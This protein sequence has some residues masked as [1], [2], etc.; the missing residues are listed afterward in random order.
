MTNTI[1]KKRKVFIFVILFLLFNGILFSLFQPSV[2]ITLRGQEDTL[3]HFFYDNLSEDYPFDD[4]HMATFDYNSKNGIEAIVV[5]V[6]L[7]N[8]N[9]LRI[10]F[11]T[12]PTS[13]EIYSFSILKSPIYE[14]AFSNEE[15]KKRFSNLNDIDNLKIVDQYIDVVT[16]GE[17]GHIYSENLLFG[18]A[19]SFRIDFLVKEFFLIICTLLLVNLA[20]IINLLKPLLFSIKKINKKLI[21]HPL[22]KKDRI[23]GLLLVLTYSFILAFFTDVVVFRL[24]AKTANLFGFDTLYRYFS[25]SLFFSL[26]RV[27]FIFIF[28]FAIGIVIYL[29]IRKAVR[30]RYGIAFLFLLL[31]VIGKFTGSSLGFYDGMLQGNTANYHE[32]TLL[33]IPQGIRGDEWATEKPY[34]FAQIMGDNELPYFNKNLSFD[35]N[36]MVVSAFAPV[37]DITILARPDLWGF[38]FLPG[39]YAFSFYWCFRLILLFMASFEMGYLLTKR[40]RYAILAAFII[41]FAPPVQWWLS[42]TLM[43]MLMSGQFAVVLFDKYLRAE[44]N[45]L[46]SLVYWV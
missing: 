29:G 36:D 14:I 28:V 9:K 31:M 1:L 33:G 22:S 37:K 35:G 12:V 30:Y 13:F 7:K 18:T 25:K 20:I 2:K 23:L 4:S 44:K 10:D 43:L 27:Y 16:T 6:P 42:Q 19:P 26:D 15:F 41:C 32:S 34:Y 24:I 46:R 8:L 21:C 5:K 40:Y 17:D 3:L 45:I 11:G 39:E 38:L